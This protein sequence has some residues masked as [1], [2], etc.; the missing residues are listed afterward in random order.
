MEPLEGTGL[1]IRLRDFATRPEFVYS[2]RW[3]VGDLVM[4]D[5]TGTLHRATPY[6]TDCDRLL[7]RTKLEGDEAIV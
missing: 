3:K 2:H 7:H 6:P 5:N 4:W 1:L